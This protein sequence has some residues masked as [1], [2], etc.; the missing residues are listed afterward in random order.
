[1]SDQSFSVGD[2]VYHKANNLRMVLVKVNTDST[3]ECRYLNHENKF[4]E[5]Q[6]RSCELS[7][8][9]IDELHKLYTLSK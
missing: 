1:M 6:F 5:G 7:K 4:Y 3:F 2:V 9:S 8:R